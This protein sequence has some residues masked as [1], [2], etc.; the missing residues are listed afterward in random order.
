MIGNPSESHQGGDTGPSKIQSAV[1][2]RIM[3]IIGIAD[4]GLSERATI[5]PRKNAAQ[6]ASGVSQ[7][8]GN[9]TKRNSGAYRQTK[10]LSGVISHTVT[11]VTTNIGAQEP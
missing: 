7:R 3:E 11:P 4:A 5:S 2:A 6:R 10:A 8:Q 9:C 1:A